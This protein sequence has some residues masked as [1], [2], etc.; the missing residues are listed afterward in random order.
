MKHTD[1]AY[2]PQRSSVL[3]KDHSP[4]V[5]QLQSNEVYESTGKK[6]NTCGMLVLPGSISY[7]AC[8]S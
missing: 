8:Q 3:V 2:I 6:S 5:L 1:E 7:S 4:E